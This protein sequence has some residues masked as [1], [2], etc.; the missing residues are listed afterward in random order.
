MER[1]AGAQTAGRPAGLARLIDEAISAFGYDLCLLARAGWTAALRQRAQADAPGRGVR[2]GQRSR[3]GRARRGARVDE[4]ELSDREGSAPTLAEGEDVVRVMTV[5]QAKGLEF[6][7]VVLA[8]LGADF[9][10]PET[11]TFVVGS[12]G[13]VGVFLKGY[14]HKTYEAHDPCWG[15]AAEIAAEEGRRSERRTSGCSTWP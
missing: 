13:R 10:R 5:H 14:R 8:G 1:L 7:V 12:D 2:A 15:P 6:P 3:P 11:S 9:H 4:D